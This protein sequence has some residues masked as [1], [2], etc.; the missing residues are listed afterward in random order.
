MSVEARWLWVAVLAFVVM[1][2]WWLT[3]DD[4]VPDYDSGFHE[5][6]ASVIH[7][8]IASGRITAPF[9]DFNTYPPLVHFVGAIAIFLAGVHSMALILSSNVVFVPLLAFGCY[10]VGKLAYGRRAGLLAGVLALG[11]PMIVS[12]MHEY[13]LDAPQAALIAVSVWA[14]LETR[15]FERV[16]VALLAGALGGLALMTK[17]TSVIF[18]AGIVLVSAVRAGPGRRRGMLAYAAGI[19]VVA[20]PWYVYHAAQLSLTLSIVGNLTPNA[21]QSP[22]VWSL[23]SFDWYGWNLVNQQVLAPAALAFG[24]GTA[25]ALGRLARGRGRVAASN[26][27]P[28]LLGGALVSYV[29]MTLMLHKDPRYTLPMLVYVAVLATGWI[30]TLGHRRWRAVLSAA[31]VVSAA[32]YFVGVSA[33]IGGPVRISLPG[34]QQSPIERG[35]LTLY[36]PGG[37]IRGGPVHDG[38]VQSLLASLHASGIR[39]VIFQTGDDPVDFNGAGLRFMAVAQGLR[40][41]DA[42]AFSANRQ[43]S[44]V[45]SPPGAATPPPCQ[46]LNDGSRIYVLRGVE[47]LGLNARDMRYP[48]HPDRRYTLI[49]PGRPALVYP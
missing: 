1:S 22:P 14:L 19:C 32:A 40:D 36:A 49:C 4:R 46:R 18:L 27:E 30:A 12:T 23:A 45:L 16:R 6:F 41:G 44:L 39:D 29:G 3:Q 43:A 13:Y 28:E 5:F 26:V 9:T 8:E 33:G 11:S 10:G 25:L 2:V 37:W 38:D 48:G 31:V 24:I 7:T 20:G 47:G 42:G 34:A 17:E 21:F 35:Q 15:H